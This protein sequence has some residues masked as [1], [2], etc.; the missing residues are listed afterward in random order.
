MC[1]LKAV[2]PTQTLAEAYFLLGPLHHLERALSLSKLVTE[3]KFP[4][5]QNEENAA[6]L[7]GQKRGQ[8]QNGKTASEAREGW[9]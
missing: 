1:F 6:D 4:H 7:K 9:Q 2:L 5:R 8:N 3:L